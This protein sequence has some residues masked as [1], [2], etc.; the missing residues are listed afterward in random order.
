MTPRRHSGVDRLQ[1]LQGK[2]LFENI[3]H[4]VASAFSDDHTC[5]L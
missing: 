4:A 2:N 1:I 3:A 5:V